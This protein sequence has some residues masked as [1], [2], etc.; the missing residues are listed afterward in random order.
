MDCVFNDDDNWPGACGVIGDEF[1]GS[2]VCYQNGANG[3]GCR[4]PGLVRSSLHARARLG[5]MDLSWRTAARRAASPPT[6]L[7]QLLGVL[8]TRI[9]L[10]IW[11][12]IAWSPEMSQI[13]KRVEPALSSPGALFSLRTLTSQAQL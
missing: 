12:T 3:A 9:P 13:R 8:L 1:F 4:Q 5:G 11:A 2:P 7:P 10:R 6:T